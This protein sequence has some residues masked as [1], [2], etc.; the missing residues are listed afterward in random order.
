MIRHALL[1]CFLILASCQMPVKK[2][3]LSPQDERLLTLKRPAMAQPVVLDVVP[4]LGKEQKDEGEKE[5]EKNEP[6]NEKKKDEPSMWDIAQTFPAYDWSINAFHRDGLT[7]EDET[8]F[9]LKGDG[10]QTPVEIVK[11]AG[12]GPAR[13]EVAIGP[14]HDGYGYRMP[15]LHYTFKRVHGG[16][17]R[18]AWHVTYH[19]HSRGDGTYGEPLSEEANRARIESITGKPYDD[20]LQHVE[21]SLKTIAE[22]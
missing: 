14:I 13:V 19:G 2:S 20:G 12:S 16:W 10:S 18:L 3:A 5:E 11:Q 8:K 22:R 9:F 15:K 1:P 4:L 17:K 21:E 7:T 6:A